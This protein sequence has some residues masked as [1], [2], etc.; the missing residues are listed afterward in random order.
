MATS[1]PGTGQLSDSLAKL[2]IQRTE[3]RS[4]RS[5]LGRRLKF[6]LVLAVLVAIAGAGLAWAARNNWISPRDN[7]WIPMPEMVQSRVEARVT[8]VT[9]ETG[10]AGD[11]TVVAT[12]YLESRWQA[13]IGARTPGRAESSNVEGGDGA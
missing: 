8:T 5:W 1:S 6:V 3:P 7:N 2:R 4:N 10:R 13:K 9:V 12:G 11:A